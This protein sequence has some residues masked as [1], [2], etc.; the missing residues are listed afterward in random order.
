M[1]GIGEVP[2][3]LGWRSLGADDMTKLNWSRRAKSVASDEE[4]ERAIGET[5]RAVAERGWSSSDA[6]RAIAANESRKRQALAAATGIPTQDL[7]GLRERDVRALTMDLDQAARR[8]R[9][10][11][12]EVLAY[13]LTR[14][15]DGATVAQILRSEGRGISG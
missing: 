7:A 2:S 10:Q 15:R 4:L 14:L 1:V 8:L 13:R 12:G 5:D 6:E 11:R 9:K 3:T